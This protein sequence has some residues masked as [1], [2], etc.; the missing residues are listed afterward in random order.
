METG[1]E[2]VV[3]L[4]DLPANLHQKVKKL[5]EQPI[6]LVAQKRQAPPAEH[7]SGPQTPASSSQSNTAAA[8][9]QPA[10]AT[11]ATQKSNND[12]VTSSRDGGRQQQPDGGLKGLKAVASQSE[13]PGVVQQTMQSLSTS[14]LAEQADKA[15]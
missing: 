13:A 12:A 15:L 8:S 3:S 2:E 11:A 4:A 7:N 10:A 14:D 6:D 9:Q 1:N 5:A